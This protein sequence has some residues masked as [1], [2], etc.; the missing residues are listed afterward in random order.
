MPV[1]AFR[2]VILGLSTYG[3]NIDFGFSRVQMQISLRSPPE[4][5][6]PNIIRRSN[7]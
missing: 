6:Y 5:Y 4:P 3:G 1:S 7:S 2:K